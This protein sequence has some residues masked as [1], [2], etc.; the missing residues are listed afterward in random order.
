MDGQGRTQA[1]LGRAIVTLGVAK[2]RVDAYRLNPETMPAPHA[3]TRA[4]LGRLIVAG[5]QAQEAALGYAEARYGLAVRDA[6]LADRRAVGEPAASR[7]TM[8]AAAQVMA[9]LAKRAAPTPAAEI[10]RDPRWGFGSIG[11]GLWL[12]IIVLAA[13]A[14][15]G[16]AGAGMMTQRGPF[17][18]TIAEHCNVHDKD[19][20]VEMLLSDDSP[21]EVVHCS[22]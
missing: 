14:M 9:D 6:A 7:A 20:L 19:V 12:P 1:A 22:A 16:T 15:L 17:T 13:G 3:L 18:R 10:T 2:E 4:D 5:S 8:V 11:D 21:Y